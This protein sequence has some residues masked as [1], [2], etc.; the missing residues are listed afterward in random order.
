MEKPNFLFEVETLEDWR[1]E[2][3]ANQVV[4]EPVEE[5][6]ASNSNSTNNSSDEP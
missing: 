5:G 6:G 4:D 1:V 2:A 3:G